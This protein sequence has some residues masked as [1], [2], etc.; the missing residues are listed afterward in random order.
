MALLMVEGF[1][2]FGTTTGVAPQPTGALAR[3]YTVVNEHMMDIE[4]GRLAGYSLEIYSTYYFC[5][6]VLTTND[7]LI[8]GMAVKFPS[9]LSTLYFFYLYDG[10][11]GG[12]NLRLNTDGSIS[13]RRGETVLGTSDPVI[14]VDTWY[15]LELKVKCNDTTG[16]YEL[17]L[18]ENN[19]LSASGV[20]TKAGTHD[21]YDTARF[22]G[23]A[24]SRFSFYDDIYICDSTG[25]IN[26]DFLGNCRV[27]AVAPDG[28][29][30][31]TF[32]TASGGSSHYLDVD[33]NPADD[34][35]TYVEDGTTGH[36]DLYDYAAMP[37]SLGAIKGIEIKTVCRNT[38]GTQYDLITPIKSGAAETDD[39][40]Q[41]LTST[42]YKTKT[43]VS[44][45]D[46]NT[47]AAWTETTVN[48]AKF[49]VKVG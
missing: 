2:S 19:I 34:D 43:R 13:V 6:K 5:T 1:E 10:T 16:T 21:Y 46:P 24:S 12:M 27:V 18:N 35:T 3:L 33:E 26:N 4:T 44:E 15:Y 8:V 23:G 22:R 40:A 17:R 25:S 45:I 11:T 20:N 48:A 9:L 31:A 38:D 49:G 41:T 32:D 36:K 14:V 37:S 28:D 7:T 47:S 42:S 30:T 39:S 29:D